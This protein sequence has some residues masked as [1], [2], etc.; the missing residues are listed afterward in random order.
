MNS[1]FFITLKKV[2]VRSETYPN[3]IEDLNSAYNELVRFIIDGKNQ[4]ND[5][6]KGYARGSYNQ[7]TELQLVYEKHNKKLWET[8][9]KKLTPEELDKL[10][11][12]LDYYRDILS[13]C[14]DSR[15]ILLEYLAN[16]YPEIFKDE[17]KKALLKQLL[18][19]SVI[20]KGLNNEVSEKTTTQLS[21][22]IS[23][24]T[25]ELIIENFEAID[26]K[27]WEYVFRTETD[28][29]TFTDLLI[30]FFEY[31]KYNLPESPI[32]LKRRCKTRLAATL[33]KIHSELSNVDKFSS[34][35]NYFNIVKSLSHFVDLSDDEIYKA[36]TR[37]RK[38]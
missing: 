2:C 38:D 16:Y 17:E 31:K 29:I 5:N 11:S 4:L 15:A 22:I 25:K 18:P 1:K 19:F 14:D 13:L 20:V 12:E 37:F 23:S 35:T 21:E 27:G 32:E 6:F 24:R 33:G 3:A 28:F 36:L 9:L 34:D 10:Q 26:K 8:D 7:I 30:N